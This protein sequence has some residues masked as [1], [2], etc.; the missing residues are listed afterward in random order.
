MFMKHVLDRIIAC[1]KCSIVVIAI[2]AL[3]LSGANAAAR[4]FAEDDPLTVKSANDHPQLIATPDSE[5]PNQG[6]DG[7]GGRPWTEQAAIFQ[8]VTL[9]P[10]LH[11]QQRL[12]SGLATSHGFRAVL[13]Q[14]LWNGHVPSTSAEVSS[15]LGRQF[16]LVGARPSGT[17]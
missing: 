14:E 13:V 10:S 8:A 17:S 7:T 6:M 4:L 5:E 15:T 9:L 1:G 12:R 2:L 11:D 3:G 16:T